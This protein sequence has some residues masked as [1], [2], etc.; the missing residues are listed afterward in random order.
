MKFDLNPDITIDQKKSIREKLRGNRSQHGNP[1]SELKK[2][3]L[4]ITAA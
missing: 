1:R 3:R 4:L 2:I